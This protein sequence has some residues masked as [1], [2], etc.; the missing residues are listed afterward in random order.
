MC[1]LDKFPQAFDRFEE[2]VD[3]RN[4]RSF[5]QLF[6]ES[7]TWGGR[8]TPMTRRQ[9]EA[10]RHEASKRGK[11]NTSV[12]RDR[13]NRRHFRDIGS[14]RFVKRK[15]FRI[16]ARVLCCHDPFYS[17]IKSGSLDQNI[18]VI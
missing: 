18:F 6:F 16:R 1:S 10:Q 15:S 2:D 11:G 8:Q 13:K 9:T 12:E 7:Q 17:P 5:Q 3:T 4:I 14:G